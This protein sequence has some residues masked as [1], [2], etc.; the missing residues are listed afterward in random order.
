[1]RITAGMQPAHIITLVLIASC[2]ACAATR[3]TTREEP[4]HARVVENLVGS[5]VGTGDTPFGEMPI[6]LAFERDGADIHAR[7]GEADMYLDFRFHREGDRWLLTEEG[8]FPGLGV[9]RHTLEP[10]GGD[11]RWA[12]RDGKLLVVTLELRDP[13]LVFTTTLRGEP[14]ATFRLTRAQPAVSSR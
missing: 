6:A 14:H 7:M 9:Q 12:T 5:W 1:M 10:A 11:A 8:K 13:A 2:V 3:E 4:A